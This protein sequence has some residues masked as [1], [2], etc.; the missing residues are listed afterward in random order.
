MKISV[1]CSLYPLD[2]DYLAPIEH[3]IKSINTHEK[4]DIETNNMSTQIY[5]DYK[6]VMKILDSSIFET[7]K[8][9][10]K[11]VIIIKMVNTNLN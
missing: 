3:F 7:F 6:D 9:N 10:E 11:I 8:R 2:K 1:E 5:G 4:I